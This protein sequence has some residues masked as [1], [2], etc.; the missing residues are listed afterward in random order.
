M[1]DLDALTGWGEMILSRGPVCDITWP[2]MRANMCVCVLV[3]Y[4]GTQAFYLS[5]SA[6]G[7]SI[8]WSY[9]NYEIFKIRIIWISSGK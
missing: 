1:V 8:S 4:N 5:Q 9:S 2:I 7:C 6:G 3:K